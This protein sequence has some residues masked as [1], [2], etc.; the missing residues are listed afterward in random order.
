MIPKMKDIWHK[1]YTNVQFYHIIMNYNTSSAYVNQICLN[2]NAKWVQPAQ[3][4]R[5]TVEKYT[6]MIKRKEKQNAYMIEKSCSL[7]WK[8]TVHYVLVLDIH[9][10]LAYKPKPVAPAPHSY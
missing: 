1:T 3:I 6:Y 2:L 4:I 9:I 7:A 8:T 5:A 10:Y